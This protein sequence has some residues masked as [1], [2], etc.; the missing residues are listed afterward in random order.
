MLRIEDAW[1]Q[2]RSPTRHA[3]PKPSSGGCSTPST[4]V[5]GMR[6]RLSAACRSTVS[7]R[8]AYVGW[9]RTA[10]LANDTSRR[11]MERVGMRCEGRAVAESPHRSG[12]WLDT[13]TYTVLADE[14]PR[15]TLTLARPVP[16]GWFPPTQ[17][18]GSWRWCRRARIPGAPGRPAIRCVRPPASRPSC[19][20]PAPQGQGMDPGGR[21]S[22]GWPSEPPVGQAPRSSRR[23]RRGSG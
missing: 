17:P 20:G 11:L 2:A 7:P 19:V 5:M 4:P 1:S 12:P 3:A 16:R 8:S 13:L 18:G 10:S 9:S 22:A 14:W 6:P 21:R 23:T 15:S